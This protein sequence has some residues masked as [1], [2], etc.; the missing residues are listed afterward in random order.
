MTALRKSSTE[1]LPAGHTVAW[2]QFFLGAGPAKPLPPLAKGEKLKLLNR[3]DRLVVETSHAVLTFS[4][5]KGALLSYRLLPSQKELL[6]GE[7]LPHFW[8]PPTD[9]DFGNGM[10]QR[11]RPWLTASQ[12]RKLESFSLRKISPR[13]VEIRILFSYPP[14]LSRTETVYRLRADGLLR[15]T[16]TFT[17]GGD[18]HPELPRHGLITRLAPELKNVAG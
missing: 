18:P 10:P 14:L 16:H 8:R 17:P 11:C 4:P 1:L 12:E 9:N 3:Q 15:V 6:A 5:L 13:E 7:L 2:E